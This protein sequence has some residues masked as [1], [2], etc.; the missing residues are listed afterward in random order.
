MKISGIYKIQSI[1][2]PERFYIGSAVDVSD[3]WRCHLKDLRRNKHHSP[4]LQRHFDKYGESDLVFIII[5]PCL[6]V[7]LTVREDTYLHPI[8]PYFNICPNAGSRLG[9]KGQIPWNKGK[10]GVYS[11]ETL[12]MMREYK[13]CLGKHNTLGKHWN[14]SEQTKQKQKIAA[15]QRKPASKET[16]EKCRIRMIGNQYAVGGKSKLGQRVSEEQKQK[17]K[18][19]WKRKKLNKIA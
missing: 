18:E 15:L 1:I 13:N 10:K 19:T 6:H 3:R 2:K 14:L 4:K 9:T 17:Q 12:K 8:K 16:I 11:E 7:F 5:E